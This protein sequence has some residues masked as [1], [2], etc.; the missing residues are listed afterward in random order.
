MLHLALLCC[1]I[2]NRYDAVPALPRAEAG[3]SHFRPSIWFVKLAACYNPANH[4][5]QL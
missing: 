4:T 2:I 1:R 5:Q 3:F